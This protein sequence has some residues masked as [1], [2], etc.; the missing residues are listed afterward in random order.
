MADNNRS[1]N[2]GNGDRMNLNEATIEELQKLPFMNTER[3]RLIT[4]YIRTN[5]PLN[6]IDEVD[7]IPGFGEKMSE[8]IAQ[9]YSVDEDG[10]GNQGDR[11]GSRSDDNNN[12][13]GRASQASGRSSSNDPDEVGER[14]SERSAS[15]SGDNT[16]GDRGGSRPADEDDGRH[17]NPGRPKGLPRDAEYSNEDRD[18]NKSRNSR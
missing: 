9:H 10:R 15:G 1:G 8:L 14:L 17:N 7:N 16:S 13:R 2:Q 5:G 3:A 4:D 18:N 6:S 12:N 11:S